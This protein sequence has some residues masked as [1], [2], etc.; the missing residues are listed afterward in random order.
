MSTEPSVLPGCLSGEEPWEEIAS[1]T[2]QSV[3]DVLLKK[4][5]FKR[6]ERDAKKLDAMAPLMKELR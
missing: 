3:T 6:G 2:G 1:K 5:Q 4:L